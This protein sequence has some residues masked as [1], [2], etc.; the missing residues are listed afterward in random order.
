VAKAGLTRRAALGGLAAA[1]L[2]ALWAAPARPQLRLEGLR[3]AL[4]AGEAGLSPGGLDDQSAAFAQ[5][6]ARA[7]AAGQ[8]L[9]LPPGRYRLAG[10]ELPAHT[11]LIGVPGRTVLEYGGGSFLMRARGS[12]LL[13]LEGM[14]LEG[15]GLPFDNAVI[16]LLE[17][18]DAADVVLNDCAIVGSGDAGLA[19][20]NAA[21]RIERCRV[22]GAATVGIDVIQSRGMAVLD[23]VVSDCGNTGI[24]VERY[25]PGSDDTIVRGNRVTEIRARSGGTGQ[26]GNGINVSK[27][28]GVIVADNRIDNC[29]FSAIR[30]FSS[31]NNALTGNLL[32]RSGEM[33]I[34]VEFAFEGAVVADNLIDGAAFGIS[35]ANFAE[36]GGRLATCSGNIVRDISGVSRLPRGDDIVGT[37]IAAEAD[38]AITGNVVEGAARGIQLGWGPYLRDVAATGNVVR[39]AEVGIGVSVVEGSG[40]ALIAGNLISGSKRAAILGMRW[41]EVASGDLASP[42]AQTFPGVTVSGNQVS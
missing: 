5:A 26:Y 24:L 25:E 20:R 1:A 7:E 6:L 21:G 32:T 27:A 13:R 39:G 2:P 19:L 18:T 8:A 14:T 38:V 33:A 28:N 37:G 29:D 16:A 23:N 17:A 30:C 15:G 35:F 3:G 12:Q 31:D 41:R 11:H 42:G 22:S 34:Y 40:P 36:H 9:F 4:D 10:I